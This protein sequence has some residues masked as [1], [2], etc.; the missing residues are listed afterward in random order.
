MRFW[1]T[2][3]VQ[4]C[5]SFC[6]RIVPKRQTD[7]P[8]SRRFNATR[9]CAGD[10]QDGKRFGGETLEQWFFLS[11][12]CRQISGRGQVAAVSRVIAICVCVAQHSSKMA[13]V[14]G[15]NQREFDLVSAGECSVETARLLMDLCLLRRKL[16]LFVLS[17][18]SVSGVSVSG[19]SGTVRRSTANRI[20]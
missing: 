19:M 20:P 12:D 6:I 2:G 15:G 18:F 17:H 14:S 7:F 8:G 11:S 10:P 3:F 4:V 16:F 13:H 5:A 9:Q 1:L